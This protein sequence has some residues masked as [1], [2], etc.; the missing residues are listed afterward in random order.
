MKKMQFLMDQRYLSSSSKELDLKSI[1]IIMDP[2]TS[3]D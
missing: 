2:K 1:K 3:K